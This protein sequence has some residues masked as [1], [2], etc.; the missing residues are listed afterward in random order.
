VEYRV[1]LNNIKLLN[2]IQLFNQSENSSNEQSS[3]LM[4]IYVLS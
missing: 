1:E 4:C 2:M 3:V